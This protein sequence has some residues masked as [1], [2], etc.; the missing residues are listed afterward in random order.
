MSYI[1]D[2]SGPGRAHRYQFVDAYQPGANAYGG[3]SHEF[4][5]HENLDFGIWTLWIS[6]RLVFRSV[7]CVRVFFSPQTLVL[8]LTSK[9]AGH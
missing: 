3:N 9:L 2:W 7:D 1:Y 6:F 4:G 8:K 5:E